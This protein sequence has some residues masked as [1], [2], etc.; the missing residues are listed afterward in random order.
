MCACVCVCV[1]HC[2]LVSLKNTEDE[3]LTGK[4]KQ[5]I[6]HVVSVPRVATASKRVLEQITGEMTT[7]AHQWTEGKDGQTAKTKKKKKIE[8]KTTICA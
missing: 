4:K 7:A 5:D 3:Y 6:K 8:K 2:Q 1:L